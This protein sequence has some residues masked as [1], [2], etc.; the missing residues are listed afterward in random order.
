[1]GYAYKISDKGA[2]TAKPI[3]QQFYVFFK[4]SS[5]ENSNY[6]KFELPFGTPQTTGGM[7]NTSN[8]RSND[9]KY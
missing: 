7:W 9:N 5:S 4:D 3:V 1:M 2:P 6:L 8:K